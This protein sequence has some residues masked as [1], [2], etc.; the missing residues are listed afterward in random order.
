MKKQKLRNILGDKLWIF[1]E[2]TGVELFFFENGRTDFKSVYCIKLSVFQHKE[3][4]F[5]S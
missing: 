1:S 5:L 4:L 3:M 2:A